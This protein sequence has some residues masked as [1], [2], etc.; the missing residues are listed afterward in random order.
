MS[1]VCFS[2]SPLEKAIKGRYRN[3]QLH[4][5]FQTITIDAFDQS[6]LVGLKLLTIYYQMDDDVIS[7]IGC[8]LAL[9]YLHQNSSVIMFL[10]RMFH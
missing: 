2:I 5:P 3:R 10:G 7:V 9:Q 8:L 6:H 4:V 1:G